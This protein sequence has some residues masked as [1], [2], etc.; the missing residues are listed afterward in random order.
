[1]VGLLYRLTQYVL[2]GCWL[3]IVVIVLIVV[4]KFGSWLVR[5]I[6][7]HTVS[8]IESCWFYEAF[9]TYQCV[10]CVRLL[11]NYR[12]YSVSGKPLVG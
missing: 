6:C 1:M 11:A 12:L 5:R 4:S 2:T 7:C 8:S 3:L 9:T 10:F